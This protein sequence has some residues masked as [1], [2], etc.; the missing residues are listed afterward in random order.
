MKCP[1]CN[2]SHI[3]DC[4]CIKEQHDLILKNE[5]TYN[6]TEIMMHVDTLRDLNK[7]LLDS[8]IRAHDAKFYSGKLNG[9]QQIKE[10]LTKLKK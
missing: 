1:Y 3:R 8:S 9:I 10:L 7:L 2:K 6:Y 4:K 5:K